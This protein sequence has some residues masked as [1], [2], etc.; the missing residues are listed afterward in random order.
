MRSSRLRSQE[1]TPFSIGSDPSNEFPRTMQIGLRRRLVF[2]VGAAHDNLQRMVGERALQ[3]L[4]L[5]PWSAHPDVT[6][7]LSR[8]DYRHRLRMDRRDN[9]VRRRG[10]ETIDKMG[11]GDRLRLRAA[12]SFEFGPDPGEAEQWAALVE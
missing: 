12:L 2:L 5:I 7:L 9:G 3:R 8:K 10:Q 11:A 6:F 1:S 4:R